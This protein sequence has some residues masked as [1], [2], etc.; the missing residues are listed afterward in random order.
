MPWAMALLTL[1][2]QFMQAAWVLPLPGWSTAAH[3]GTSCPQQA[4]AAVSQSLAQPCTNSSF[5]AVS[6]TQWIT[7]ALA[8]C[9]PAAEYRAP[10]AVCKLA[11]CSHQTSLHQDKS[12]ACKQA[13]RSYPTRVEGSRA[14]HPAL[15]ADTGSGIVI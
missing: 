7:Q 1:H 5:P 4:L 13:A 12:C 10:M 11:S 15:I 6:F 8:G 3:T 14:K 9:I 2:K